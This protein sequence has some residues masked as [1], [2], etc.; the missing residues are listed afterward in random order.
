ML[1]LAKPFVKKLTESGFQN[2]ICK[3]TRGETILGKQMGTKAS[4]YED[5][6][7]SLHL[8]NLSQTPSKFEN[9]STTSAITAKQVK[10]VFGHF[11][12]MMVPAKIPHIHSLSVYPQQCIPV[13]A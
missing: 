13:L 9:S 7:S 10:G 3:R 5:K 6:S 2:K 4:V 12:Q 8:C 1:L 11:F